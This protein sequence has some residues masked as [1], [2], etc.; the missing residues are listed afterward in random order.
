[1][2]RL[3]YLVCQGRDEL[4]SGARQVE[5]AVAQRAA[6]ADVESNEFDLIAKRWRRRPR[7]R[8]AS[9]PDSATQER[10]RATCFSMPAR[11][12]MLTT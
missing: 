8:A 7:E 11:R 12:P 3:V 5:N 10:N 6:F 2:N 4:H 1:M 9:P